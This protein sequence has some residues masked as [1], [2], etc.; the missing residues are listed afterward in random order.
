MKVYKILTELAIWT[1]VGLVVGIGW[2][3]VPVLGL[4]V[5]F[6]GLFLIGVGMLMPKKGTK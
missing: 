3:L 1:G 6:Y 4:A 2:L 5:V